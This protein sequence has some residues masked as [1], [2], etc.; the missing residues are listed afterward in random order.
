MPDTIERVW[1][2]IS[3]VRS[4]LEKSNRY[5][6]DANNEFNGQLNRIFES[7]TSV[8]NSGYIL[9]RGRIYTADDKWDKSKHPAKYRCLHFAGYDADNSF[10]NKSTSWPTQGRMNPEGISCLYT[11]KDIETCIKELNPGYEELVS[12]AKIK[13]NEELRIVDLSKGSSA[14]G[15]GDDIFQ[16]YLSV[17]IQELI[18]QGGDNTQDYIFPQYI[19]EYCK[20]LKYDGIAYRSKYYSRNNVL[21][22]IGINITIFNYDKCEPISSK[23]YRVNDITL[24]ASEL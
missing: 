21:N 20:Y 8:V 18:T 1:K 16:L 22:D 10:V 11:A 14:L 4:T 9:Y 24:K 23:L 3:S 12:V 17:Y 19:A 13:V 2:Y 7:L 6:P 15:N 5:F